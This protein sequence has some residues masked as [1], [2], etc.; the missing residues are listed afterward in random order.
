GGM[1][2]AALY[3]FARR[4]RRVLGLEQFDVPNPLGAS[5]GVTR[6]IRLAYSEHPKYVPL[7]VRSYELWRAL[8]AAAGEQLLFITGG[9]DAGTESS[10]TIEGSLRSC[11]E[12]GLPHT[13]MSAA[14]VN[15]QFPGYRL[16]PDLTAVYQPQV[17]FLMS[18]RCVIAHVNGALASGAE[19][20]GRERLIDWDASGGTV[21]VTTDRGRY[22]SAALVLTAG[23]WT[24]NVDAELR[25]YIVAERQV[26]L[27]AQPRRPEY[28]EVGRFPI[29]NMEVAEGRFY[30]FPVHAVPGFKIG[31]YHHRGESVVA[32]S[33][34][35]LCHAEDE[36]VLRQGIERYFPD[37]N[38]PTLAMKV[39]MFAN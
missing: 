21:R 19:I 13:L 15:R 35:R 16:P 38:G 26:L 7:L 24:P 6:I 30:G 22:E 4:G 8:E 39:C 34:D 9:I 28:F 5:V 32:D 10:G 1:G 27:W 18:E 2:S 25:R 17:G 37:A 20:H 29:F 14:D 12:H 31:K 3:E 33:V 11:N 23:P 36:A